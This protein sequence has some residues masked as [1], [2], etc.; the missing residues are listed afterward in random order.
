VPAIQPDLGVLC[1]DE[2]G[3]LALF[4]L[5]ASWRQTPD[6]LDTLPNLQRGVLWSLALCQRLDVSFVERSCLPIVQS[7]L[8]VLR[9]HEAC[10]LALFSFV[11]SWCQAANYLHTLP[12]LKR[13]GCLR[14]RAEELLCG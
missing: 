2:A 4:P 5:V 6:D 14:T 7:D 10:D 3:D 8:W 12:D 13:N 11:A 1:I 9:V